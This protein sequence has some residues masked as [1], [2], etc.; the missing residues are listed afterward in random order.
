MSLKFLFTKYYSLIIGLIAFIIYYLTT[1]RSIGEI[2]SGELAAVQATWGIAHPTG[3]PL[4][5]ITGYLYSKIPITQPLIFQLNLLQ[6]ILNALS[7]IILVKIIELL[8]SNLK[9]FFNESKFPFLSSLKFSD[10]T[11]LFS[12]IIGGLTFAFSIT[13]WKQATRVEVY[14]LQI[15]LSSIIL[16]FLFKMLIMYSKSETIK[17]IEWYYLALFIGLAF[18]NH[19]MT[20]YLLPATIYLFFLINKFQKHSIINFLKL[21]LISFSIAFSFYIIMM[22]RAQSDPP[23]TFMNEPKSFGALVDYV[24]GKYYESKMFQGVDSIRQQS[25]QFLKI[26]SFNRENGFT[27]GEFGFIIIFVFSGL[28]FLFTFLRR[29]RIICLLIIGTSLFFVLNYSIPDID[30]YFLVIFLLFTIAAAVISALLIELSRKFSYLLIASFLILIGWQ[31]INNYPE[32]DRSND[33]VV[34]DYARSIL[35]QL[36]Q[37]SIL[38]TSDWPLIAAPSFFLQYALGYRSDVEVLG[39]EMLPRSSYKID[40]K[41]KFGSVQNLLSQDYYITFDVFKDYIK[42]GR[43]NIGGKTVIPEG[44]CFRLSNDNSY[45]EYYPELPKIRFLEKRTIFHEYIYQLIGFMIET[46]ARYELHYQNVDK[47][48]KFLSILVKEYPDYTISSELKSYLQ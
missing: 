48:K 41:K 40:V 5:A 12:S 28:I 14:S 43:Y 15:F 39:V 17:N 38:L 9:Y 1:L 23:F 25:M 29:I 45:S 44:F 31:V 13:F 3:Y 10:T 34:E 16:Y 19:L 30:E 32:I 27:G 37:N 36:P 18:S 6:C 22:L 42:K 2:D 47:A 35:K 33:Y 21:F 24:S 11:I 26:L 20:L 46:R 7:V 8:L 4:F